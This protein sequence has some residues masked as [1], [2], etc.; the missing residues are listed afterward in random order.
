MG[1]NGGGEKP[2]VKDAAFSVAGIALRDSRFFIAR[3]IPG[4]SLGGKWEFP[5]GKVEAGE[6]PEEALIREFQEEFSLS[7]RVGEE[8]GVSRFEHKGLERTLRAHRIYFTDDGFAAALSLT[9][10]E[11]WKWATL[12]EIETLDFAPSDTKLLPALK[13]YLQANP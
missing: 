9:D 3:R 4:G 8:L 10:H 5:G 2:A 1:E 12:G 13:A 6:S 11:E 7:I